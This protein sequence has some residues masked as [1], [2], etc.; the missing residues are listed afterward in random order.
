MVI[1]QN[2]EN[3]S[4][5]SSESNPVETFSDQEDFNLEEHLSRMGQCPTC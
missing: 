3:Q 1:S 2:C 4:R 5:S